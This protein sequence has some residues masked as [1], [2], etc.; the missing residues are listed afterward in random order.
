MSQQS[1]NEFYKN[2]ELTQEEKDAGWYIDTCHGNTYKSGCRKQFKALA[3]HTPS[4]C[5]HCGA[6][7]VD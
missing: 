2:T 1:L 7:F 5:P 6:T 3:W 4:G